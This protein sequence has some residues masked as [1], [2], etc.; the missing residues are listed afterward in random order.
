MA[1]LEDTSGNQP[2]QHQH[3]ADFSAEA[4]AAVGACRGGLM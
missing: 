2:Q 1:L 3:G 4:A